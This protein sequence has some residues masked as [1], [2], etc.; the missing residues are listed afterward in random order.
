MR[1]IIN[2][3]AAA[4]IEMVGRITGGTGGREVREEVEVEDIIITGTKVTTDEIMQI[5]TPSPVTTRKTRDPT[6]TRRRKARAE[7]LTTAG[8]RGRLAQRMLEFVIINLTFSNQSCVESLYY[9]YDYS[10]ESNEIKTVKLIKSFIN[11]GITR[12]SYP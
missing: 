8:R 6:I 9:A 4:A 3:G 5:P 11:Q 2:G 1:D 10:I 7:I 12:V